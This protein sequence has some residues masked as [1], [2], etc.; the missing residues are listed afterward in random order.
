VAR[1]Y[2]NPGTIT[3]SAVIQHGSQRNS[4]GYISF[5]YDLKETYGV[6]NLVPFKAVFDGRVEYQG[7]LAKMGGPQAMI[8]LRKDVVAQLGKTTGDSVEVAVE[9]DDKPRVLLIPR[10]LKTALK[11]SE[12]LA[13][14]EKLAY[15]HRR[16]Y[17]Q[18]IESAKKIET[19]LTRIQ[20]TLDKLRN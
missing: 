4:W 10:D 11:N 12:V 18:W 20:K 5:P 14:F 19:R 9:L 16:E 2:T 8:L 6:G 1:N 15:S 3:F 7:S 13:A 17:V